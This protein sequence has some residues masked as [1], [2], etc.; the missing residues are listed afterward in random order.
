MFYTVNVK[1]FQQ[2][3]V[4]TLAEINLEKLGIRLKLCVKRLLLR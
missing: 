3:T 4:V 1:F 2:I